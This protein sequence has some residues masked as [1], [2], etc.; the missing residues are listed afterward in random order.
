MFCYQKNHPNYDLYT[1]LCSQ[2][3]SSLIRRR[4]SSLH[5]IYEIPGTTGIPLPKS[6]FSHPFFC[7]HRYFARLTT[8]HTYCCASYSH[9]ATHFL[10][11]DV[12]LGYT[13]PGIKHKFDTKRYAGIIGVFVVFGITVFIGY[14]LKKK[15]KNFL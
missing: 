8:F 14:L 6:V 3:P 11:F 2:T 4:A 1:S 7:L 5:T 9:Y 10:D 12:T 13:V 15:R